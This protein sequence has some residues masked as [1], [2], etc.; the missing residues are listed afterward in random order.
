MPVYEYSALDSRGK[1]IKG[2]IDADS[3]L[4]A[5]N[6]L[7]GS[8]LFPVKIK[9]SSSRVKSQPVG[10]ASVNTLLRRIKASEISTI[11]RQ[12]ATLMSAGIPL[13]ASLELLITQ[14]VNP[15]LKKV[16][17]QTKESVNEGN[18]LASS[19]A[20][21][22]RYFSQIYINMVTAGE[23][24]GSLDLVLERL[25]EFSENQEALK[26]K[27]ISSMVYPVIMLCIGVS[28]LL[29]LVTFVVPKFVAVF[30]EMEKALPL[31][32]LIVIG[33][34]NFLKSYWW[35]ILL[36]IIIAGFLFR[37]AKRTE[38]FSRIWDEI[39]LKAPVFGPVIKRMIIARFARTLGSLLQSGVTLINALH[40]VRN[41][42]NNILVA[43][44]I[45]NAVEEIKEGKTLSAPLSKNSLIP[46]VVVQMISVG[47]HSGELEK[48]LNK[49]A[50]IYEREVESK[51]SSITAML[52]P[53]M[54]LGMAVIVGFIAFSILLPIME[55][56]QIVH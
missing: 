47:E 19:L 11:T 9:E 1:Q 34:S 48:M 2:I 14:E 56:S 25:A 55:M 40:I 21:H 52:E 23:A 13:V 8:D 28:A 36:I 5:R 17:A 20:Q 31:P 46:P 10:T 7:R 30:D 45:D 16:L 35:F 39:K 43:E 29:L 54:L 38:R 51:V 15:L 42:V 44:I 27:V 37:H 41:V 22:S 33:T 4:S 12:L 24:S 49:I 6:K 3:P 32:T 50:D 26:S 53:F 18:S